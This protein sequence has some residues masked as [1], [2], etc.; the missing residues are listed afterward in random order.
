MTDI[1]FLSGTLYEVGS[2]D[3]NR[4]Q[5]TSCKDTVTC[6]TVYQN[7]EQG[8]VHISRLG[9]NITNRVDPTT[10]ALIKKDN[11]IMNF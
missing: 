1:G 7:T 5:D 4:S 6:L 10:H 3:T 8:V 9:A 11:E 2:N